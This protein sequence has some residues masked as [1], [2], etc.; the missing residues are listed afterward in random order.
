MHPLRTRFVK[1]IVTEFFPPARPSKRG[2][3]KVI[4]ILAGVPGSP[5]KPALLEF[6]SKKG[7]WAFAPRYRG[8]WESGGSFLKY[9]PHEDVIAALD[10]IEKGFTEVFSKTKYALTPKEVVLLGG[11]FG[12]PAALLASRDPRVTKVITVAGVV[13]WLAKSKAEPISVFWRMMRDGFGEAYRG[14]RA[15]QKKIGKG[16]FYNPASHADTIEGRKVF[17]IHAKDDDVVLVRPVV[18]F[19]KQIG[20][21]LLLLPRGGHISSALIA[22]RPS[23][24]KRIKD[25]L[26]R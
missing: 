13:D 19:A 8:A 10:G 20:A 21:K 11:S 25:F 24:Y 17:M 2:K 12:G 16:S 18:R 1:D 26:K 14:S 23:L 15:D 5:S 4:I 7:Y 22:Q 9:S 6:F 3:E